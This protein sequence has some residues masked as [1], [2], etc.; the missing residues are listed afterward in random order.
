MTPSGLAAQNGH[1]G[2]EQLLE[3]KAAELVHGKGSTS[4]ED[5]MDTSNPS[6]KGNK[7]KRGTDSLEPEVGGRGR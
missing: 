6:S 2:I 5:Q 7:R 3:D 4:C 1:Y